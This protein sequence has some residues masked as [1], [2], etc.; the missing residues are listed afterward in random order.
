ME[1]K[2]RTSSAAFHDD[3]DNEFFDQWAML[4][5][6]KRILE[7]VINEMLHDKTSGAIM[8]INGNK[9]GEWSL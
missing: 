6:S 4:R 2:F 9:I 5:E 3:S 1:I 8:D 7:K